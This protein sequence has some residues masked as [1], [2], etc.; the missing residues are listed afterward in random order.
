MKLSRPSP[1]CSY[2]WEQFSLRC[3]RRPGTKRVRATHNTWP[4]PKKI[5]R[6]ISILEKDI[7]G[8]FHFPKRYFCFLESHNWKRATT[9]STCWFPCTNVSSN[10]TEWYWNVSY[11]STTYP[12]ALY[13]ATVL[14]WCIG[15]LLQCYNV[16]RPWSFDFLF[17][18]LISPIATLLKNWTGQQTNKCKQYIELILTSE[19]LVNIT[20][21][22]EDQV[23][24][25][26]TCIMKMFPVVMITILW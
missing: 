1:W 15:A 22:F 7:S 21:I 14:R 12:N 19:V 17:A 26:C 8:Y 11:H 16:L 6:T 18:S 13:I 2:C 24:K 5:F 10:D 23:N 20:W 25:T 3:K 4:F 9:F